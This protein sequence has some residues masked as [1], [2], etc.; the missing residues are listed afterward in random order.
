VGDRKPEDLTAEVASGKPAPRVGF[1]ASGA[2]ESPAESKVRP[3]FQPLGGRIVLPSSLG[4]A[5]PYLGTPLCRGI[6]FPDATS[7]VM[8]LGF[9]VPR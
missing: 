8:S 2:D 4:C 6:G 7:A 1:Y 3:F 5:F 9:P